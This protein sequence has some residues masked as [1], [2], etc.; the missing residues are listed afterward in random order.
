MVQVVRS[1]PNAGA[2]AGERKFPGPRPRHAGKG[3]RLINAFLVGIGTMTALAVGMLW[4]VRTSL[5]A[6]L[7][8]LCREGTA[9]S[10]GPR[11]ML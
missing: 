3:I 10:S 2:Q 5:M 6:L 4:F 1:L 11:S 8:D 7:R 9:R